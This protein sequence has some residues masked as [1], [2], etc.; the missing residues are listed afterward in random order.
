VSDRASANQPE[1][2]LGLYERFLATGSLRD[3]RRLAR[4]G[5]VPLPGGRRRWQ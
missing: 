3:R 1:W 2:L 4:A 5:C